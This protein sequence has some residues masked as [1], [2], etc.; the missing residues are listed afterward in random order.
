MFDF[1]LKNRI[2]RICKNNSARQKVFRSLSEIKTV[3]VVFET[4]DYEASDAFIEQLEKMGKQVKAYAFRSKN[5][6]YDYTET[7]YKII[8]LKEDTDWLGSPWADLVS[9]L[10][11]KSFDLLIDLTIKENLTLEYLV[12][13]W[14]IPLKTGFKKN[15]LPLYDLAISHLPG[16]KGSEA[17]EL[18][19]QILYYL[20]TIHSKI[21]G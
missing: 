5:D 13:Y 15:N 14:D 20:N 2:K 12:A 4:S 9:S 8:N 6:Q 16:D 19:A 21:T 17:Q 3:V 1:I 7:P 18:G 10:D 11:E